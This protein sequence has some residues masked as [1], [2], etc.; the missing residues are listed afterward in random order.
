M[1]RYRQLLA[2]QGMT[3]EMFENRAHDLA[4]PGAGVRRQSGLRAAGAGRVA[5]GS[6]F[7][8]ARRRS[9]ASHGRLPA[10]VQPTE[11]SCEA[12]YKANA[13]LFQAPEQASIEYVV[14]DLATVQKGITVNERT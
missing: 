1:E 5:L 12:F 9:R 4:A 8:R 14:L 3:P 6:F 2:A 11:P 7:E 10:K 13:Q